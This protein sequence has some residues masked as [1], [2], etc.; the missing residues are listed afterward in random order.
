MVSNPPGSIL[1]A[2]NTITEIQNIVKSAIPIL[3]I[4]NPRTFNGKTLYEK[5]VRP[6]PVLAVTALMQNRFFYNYFL[7]ENSSAYLSISK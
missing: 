6:Q 3:T 1:I 2:K 5:V 4:I 7:D